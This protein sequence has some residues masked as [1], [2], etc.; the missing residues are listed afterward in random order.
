MPPPSN[1][2]H[3]KQRRTKKNDI[4]PVLEALLETDTAGDPMGQ[5][6]QWCRRSTRSL[7]DELETKDVAICANSVGKML[8]AA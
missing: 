5:K 1:A 4:I 2:T 3:T 6:R 7:S 8:K